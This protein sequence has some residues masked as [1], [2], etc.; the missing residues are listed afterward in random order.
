MFYPS[1]CQFYIPFNK[2]IVFL[3]AHGLLLRRCDP[4]E[5]HKLIK[6]IFDYPNEVFSLT[7]TVLSMNTSIIHGKNST[8]HLFLL[9]PCL[10]STNRVFPSFSEILVA[11]LKLKSVPHYQEMIDRCQR[12]HISCEFTTLKNKVGKLSLSIDSRLL[13]PFHMFLSYHLNDQ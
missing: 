8:Y 10:S 3:P 2:T 13:L 5:N 9:P 7:G 4:Q 6:W 11:H 12:N 1:F